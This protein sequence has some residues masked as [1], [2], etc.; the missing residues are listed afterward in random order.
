MQD[1]WATKSFT[2]AKVMDD[3]VDVDVDIYDYVYANK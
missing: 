2:L 1:F 3:G